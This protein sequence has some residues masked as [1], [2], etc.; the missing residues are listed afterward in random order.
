V[1]LTVTGTGGCTDVFERTVTV[2][3]PEGS[4]VYAPQS[5]CNPVTVNF[6]GSTNSRNTF[7]WDFNDGNTL[8]TAD[9]V[10]SHTYTYPGYYV[11]KLILVDPAGCQVPVSGTDTI[12]VGDITAKLSFSTAL[13]CDS[14]LV[15]FADSSLVMNDQ[16]TSYQWHFGDGSSSTLS[17]PA[18]QYNTTGTYYPTLTVVTAKGCTDSLRAANP[19]KVVR[20]PQVEMV[21]SGNGC[22]PLTATFSGRLT[23][24]DTSAITWQWDFAN[25]NS[26]TDATPGTQQF[27][28][29][30]YNVQ[31]TGTNSSGCRGI[32][33]RLVEAY[34]IPSVNAGTDLILCK[35]SPRT[36]QASGA[37]SYSWSP[38][39]GLDCTNCASPLTSTENNIT[40]VVTGT[41][42]NG[43][44]GSD[45]VTVTVKEKFRFTYSNSDSLCRGSSK[46]MS[47]A[48]ADSYA[49]TPVAGLD[50]P[51]IA[52][53]TAR[54]DTSTTYRVIG[55]DNL[56][57]CKDTGYIS[58]RVN[59]IPT[60]EA[61]PDKTVN[62][63]ST[64]DLVPVISPDVT[65]VIWQPTTGLFRN[66]YPGITVKPTEN[67]EY[68]VEVKNR[69]GCRA[70]DFVTVFVVCNGANIFVPNTFSPNND[71][72]NDF[73]F[74]RG[75]GVFK[76]RNLR[77]FTRWGEL[78]W[79]RSN[80]DANN[81]AF[82][83]N[84]T[85]KGMQ[86]NPDVFIY[87]LEIMC[88][89]GSVITHRGNIALVK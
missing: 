69:G 55:A 28:T 46:K 52:D 44:A 70:K 37:D 15:I 5:G 56:G 84:G 16:I 36:L 72:T 66:F 60:V 65:E 71:G 83:W 67:T 27:T 17:N 40:Y 9:S 14:G 22:A 35:G 48:G 61:G 38:S 51:G 50:N 8:S 68:T 4:F 20:S 30:S 25:G 85:N 58:I 6:T 23:A 86:L 3:G 78:I 81:P 21:Y 75:T 31:L 63:G 89:N 45:S 53:P 12:V 88:D 87:T 80:F 26:S 29:G 2:K 42:V 73:F 47:A 59:P 13:L 18:H 79:D 54:P 19:V 64:L 41:T 32:V 24:A 76:I 10:V 1:K 57:C 43:C 39:N 34:A 77:I 74:P 82:G 7:I 11:P 62:V 33:T 49:W